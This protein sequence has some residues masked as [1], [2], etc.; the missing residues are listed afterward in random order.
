METFR[1]SFNAREMGSLFSAPHVTVLLLWACQGTGYSPQ[2]LQKII[3]QDSTFCSKILTTAFKSH[4]ASIDPAIPLGSALKA[5]SLPVIK[6]LAIQSAKQ[7]VE[8]DLDS[9]CVQFAR[10]LWFYSQVASAVARCVAEKIS[11]PAPEEAQI[12]GLLSNIGMHLLFARDPEGYVATAG[13]SLSSAEVVSREQ[14][15]LETDHLQAADALISG[16]QLESFMADAVSFMHLDVELCRGASPLIRI[17]RLAQQVC[18]SPLQLES[19]IVSAGEQLFGFGPAETEALFE[20]AA[21]QYRSLSPLGGDAEEGFK[22][23]RKGQKR[24]TSVVFSIA[25]QDGVCSRVIDAM[26]LQG[27]VESARHLYLH[28]SAAQEVIF[29]TIDADT[30]TLRGLPSNRQHRLVSELTSPLDAGSLMAEALRVGKVRHSFNKKTSELSVF[31]RQLTRVCRSKGIACLPLS[32]EG[33]L[34]GGVALG[35][36]NA[37][38]AEFFT[39]PAMRM[40]SGSVARTLSTLISLPRQLPTDDAGDPAVAVSK[41]IHEVSN[42]LAIISNYMAAVGSLSD[43][44]RRA[45]VY[46]S[47]DNELRRIGKILKYYGGSLEALPASEAGLDLNQLL[48]AALESL[49]QTSF[50]P[51]K[52]EVVTELDMSVRPVNSKSVAITQILVNLLKNAAE[53]LHEGGTITITTRET[54][55]S[56]V[57]HYAEICVHDNGPGIDR[58]IQRQ[59]FS[60]VKSTKGDGHAGLGLSIVKEM[61]NDIEGQIHCHSSEESGTSFSLLIPLGAG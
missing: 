31:D 16:W 6:S 39:E 58:E 57:R 37:Y 32:A 47:I 1:P 56:G 19:S 28:S 59:L 23:F 27:F 34:V 29:F 14:A 45:E 26:D 38:E 50:E 18:R 15:G 36:E 48:L 10:E 9:A 33:R 3:L 2:D 35:V 44:A 55:S 30:S 53:A 46:S 49:R 20:T 25:G 8:H 22:E 43:E 4:A 21:A 5:L 7:V 11:Y 61:V 24:L 13:S 51:K 41:L 42:P 40:L 52:I 60:P 12:A 17:V 54:V